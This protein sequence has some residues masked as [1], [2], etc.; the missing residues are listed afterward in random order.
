[1]GVVNVSCEA[2]VSTNL[3]QVQNATVE[4][5]GAELG[6]DYFRSALAVTKLSHFSDDLG[7]PLHV[8]IGVTHRLEFVA[9]SG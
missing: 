8:W 3:K 5:T 7:R 1:M 9:V 4:T 6:I 2:M